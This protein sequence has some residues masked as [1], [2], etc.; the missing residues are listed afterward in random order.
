MINPEGVLLNWLYEV[1]WEE[2][3][4]MGRKFLNFIPVFKLK[5][6]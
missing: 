6:L 5:A 4:R 1:N 2:G 3:K